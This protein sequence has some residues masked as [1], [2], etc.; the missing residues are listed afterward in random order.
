MY[1]CYCFLKVIID[2]LVE[3]K[4]VFLCYLLFFSC[5]GVNCFEYGYVFIVGVGLGDVELFM[6]K[7]VNVI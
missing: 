2:I 6:V 3:L 1:C 4:E 7:V 5:F